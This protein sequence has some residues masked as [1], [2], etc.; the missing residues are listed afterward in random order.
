MS[1]KG[2]N[3]NKLAKSLVATSSLQIT[4]YWEKSF[5]ARKPNQIKF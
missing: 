4:N 1:F 2:E 5:V 3:Y